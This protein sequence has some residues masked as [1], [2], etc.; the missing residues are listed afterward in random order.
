MHACAK[1]T[2]RG[3]AGSLLLATSG[4]EAACSP[5]HYLRF[6]LGRSDGALRAAQCAAQPGG[7]DQGASG[8]TT[9]PRGGKPGEGR[10]GRA[11]GALDKATVAR[12]A[13]ITAAVADCFSTMT[14]A[15]IEALTP[16][17]LMLRAMHPAAKNGD[18]L[19]AV[20]IA[21]RAAPLLQRESC[22]DVGGCARKFHPG[23]VGPSG[24]VA[25]R[26]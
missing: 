1:G 18:T 23:G 3:L 19:L 26:A 6:F 5:L 4:S 12:Q 9:N 11:K 13:A 21:E 2:Q 8:Q 20:N 17:E 14:L 25:A 15:E 10:G 7:R 24:R 16:A 22:G